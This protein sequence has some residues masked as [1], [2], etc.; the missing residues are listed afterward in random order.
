[1]A[2]SLRPVGTNTLDHAGL[3]G[4]ARPTIQLLLGSH[5]SRDPF[6]RPA[7]TG[8]FLVTPGTSC[9]ATIMLSLRDE[10]HSPDEAKGHLK[11]GSGLKSKRL[12][13]HTDPPTRP[14]AD[15]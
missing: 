5:L 8:N 10:I 9:L 7:G 11:L 14:S 13:R 1:M 15:P 3:A 4:G 6:N 12:A 2:D